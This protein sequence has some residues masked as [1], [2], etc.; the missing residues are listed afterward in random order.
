MA[1]KNLTP[2]ELRNIRAQFNP[3]ISNEELE[4]MLHDAAEEKVSYSGE[5]PIQDGVLAYCK[6]CKKVWLESPANKLCYLNE[7]I[8]GV[9]R[10]GPYCEAHSRD[11]VVKAFSS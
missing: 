7:G 5:M 2:E 1:N 10:E 9:K 4:S 3:R 6:Q 8:E 11:I